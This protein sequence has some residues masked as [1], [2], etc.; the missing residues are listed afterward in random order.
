MLSIPCLLELIG[1]S[2][3]KSESGDQNMLNVFDFLFYQVLHEYDYFLEVHHQRFPPKLVLIKLRYVALCMVGT[4]NST[5]I[6][7]H[8][9]SLGFVFV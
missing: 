4:Y 9:I 2:A 1:Q 7:E 6:Y 3:G 8:W 5:Y